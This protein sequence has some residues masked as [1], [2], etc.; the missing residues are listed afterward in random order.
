M[1]QKLGGKTLLRMLLN[2]ERNKKGTDFFIT[3]C[4]TTI[5]F[6]GF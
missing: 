4:L 6:A 2:F 3:Y 5:S 1:G